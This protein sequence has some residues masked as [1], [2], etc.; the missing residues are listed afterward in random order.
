VSDVKPDQILLIHGTF[1]SSDEDDG[2]A[3]WQR[4]SR[5]WT[6]FNQSL[7][8]RATCAPQTGTVF[9][10]SGR[11]SEQERIRAGQ[12]LFKNW[13]RLYERSGTRYHLIGHSHGGSVI[14]HALQ[15]AVAARGVGDTTDPLPHLRSWTTV[16]TPFIQIKP[17]FAYLWLAIVLLTS[18]LVLGSLLGSLFLQRNYTPF[19]VI[20]SF[21]TGVALGI[22]V[23]LLIVFSA[24][25]IISA[26]R[27]GNMIRQWLRIAK[28]D[29]IA[30]QAIQLYGMRWNGLWSHD[31]EAIN[32]LKVS[33]KNAPD[34]ASRFIKLPF[35]SRITDGIS[36]DLVQRLIQGNDLPATVVTSV[37]PSP[38]PLVAPSPMSSGADDIRLME[39]SHHSPEAVS[40]LRALLFRV[41]DNESEWERQEQMLRSDGIP[42]DI[43]LRHTSYFHIEVNPAQTTGV[44]QRLASEILAIADG[45]AQRSIAANETEAQSQTTSKR[46][47]PL[48]RYLAF[49]SVTLSMLLLLSWLFS[50]YAVN[51]L[52]SWTSWY[53]VQAVRANAPIRDV[54][55][56]PG[57]RRTDARPADL[58]MGTVYDMTAADK[59]V[60]DLAIRQWCSALTSLHISHF[61]PARHWWE[62]PAVDPQGGLT[63]L[64]PLEQALESIRAISSGTSRAQEL[65]AIALR[66]LA[67][68]DEQGAS[69]ILD[70]GIS[71]ESEF[72]QQSMRRILSMTFAE[73]DRP[74]LA[75]QFAEALPRESEYGE[76]LVSIA[77]A[78]LRMKDES[79][80]SSALDEAVSIIGTRVES[81]LKEWG[82]SM[83]SPKREFDAIFG[84]FASNDLT[85]N[86]TNLAKALLIASELGDQ[87]VR[88]RIHGKVS[89]IALGLPEEMRVYVQ[90]AQ[91]ICSRG[92]GD[93]QSASICAAA[94]RS[95]CGN[96][97]EGK[98]NQWDESADVI[99]EKAAVLYAQIGLFSEAIE[100][101]SE[102]GDESHLERCLAQ[103]G[104]NLIESEFDFSSL[105][106]RL[107]EA[108]FERTKREFL[109]GAFPGHVK[110]ERP[111]WG[112]GGKL[113]NSLNEQFLRRPPDEFSR[114]AARVTMRVISS[115]RLGGTLGEAN[116]SSYRRSQFAGLAKLQMFKELDEAIQAELESLNGKDLGGSEKVSRLAGIAHG[117]AL[118][119]QVQECSKIISSLRQCEPTPHVEI[120]DLLVALSKMQVAAQDKPGAINSIRSALV[121]AREIA[122]IHE[123]YP[124][125]AEIALQFSSLHLEKE[126]LAVAREYGFKRLDDFIR[127]GHYSES[128][129]H[130]LSVADVSFVRALANIG[131]YA[132]AKEFG[133]HLSIVQKVKSYSVIVQAFADSQML[134]TQRGLQPR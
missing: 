67:D 91:A 64:S 89:E 42:W 109:E 38:D 55:I 99:R 68:G 88:Q 18:L 21:R 25:A 71:N 121:A 47:D 117:Y 65:A 101:A 26:N 19:N 58:F 66:L 83:V 15:A 118:S 50:G 127:P 41:A 92:V 23:L 54:A 119:G 86:A 98:K 107:C 24:A 61:S 105:S 6:W 108:D 130:Q 22:L 11:N 70:R 40:T 74:Q 45:K 77:K 57:Q 46:V 76:C 33:T 132:A 85:R 2:Q 37:R 32:L 113:L 131:R 48:R 97:V 87:E 133:D 111:A 106:A 95:W 1:A 7:Q 93:L 59:S 14:W 115:L 102:I 43:F 10:W 5:F 62:S 20:F 78:W 112:I 69:E 81:V 72:A 122:S 79:R 49:A 103:I 39:I 34:L 104:A 13:L 27:V 17:R 36:W 4:G 80:A 90:A 16:G 75:T 3:W 123:Q 96:A 60:E 8:R 73:A 56:L 31:D 116:V 51:V 35:L 126:A 134:L 120:A 9:R 110:G 29:Q 94:V 100:V 44:P 82:S 28:A 30:Q 129:I 63:V 128:R 12:D 53:P 84:A 114:Q 52:Y 124:I 125:M